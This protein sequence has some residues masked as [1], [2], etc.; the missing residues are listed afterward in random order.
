MN[1]QPV[2][3]QG[4]IVRLAP[5][6]EIYVPDLTRL[7]KEP[8]IWQHLP[9]GEIAS[10]GDMRRLVKLLLA[11][12]AQGTDLPFVVIHRESNQPVGCTRYLEIRLFR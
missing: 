10:E 8:M 7:G 4:K 3:L 12:A 11:R 2:T 6:S 5:L 9:Y 1:I